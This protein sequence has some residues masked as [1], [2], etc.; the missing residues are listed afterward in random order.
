MALRLRLG[1]NAGMGDLPEAAAQAGMEVWL[2]GGGLVVTASERAARALT[3]AYHRARRAEG[4]VAWPAPQIQ[5]WQS[6]IRGAWNARG[7]GR[8]LLNT[9]QEQELW[10]QIVGASQAGSALLECSRQRMAA[11]AMEG[12]AL[13]CAYA[14][15]YLPPQQRPGWQQDAEAFS[16]WLAQFDETC[17]AERLLS[18]AR[19]PLE[20]LP[21]VAAESGERPALLL[22]GFDRMLPVQRRIF[23]A[24]GA[25]RPALAGAAAAQV[26][27]YEAADTHRELMACA[28][29]CERQL[30]LNPSARLLV[31]TQD[32]GT[33]RGEVER[34]FLRMA[35]QGSV[36]P[37]FEFSLGV[38]LSSIPLAR[39]ARLILRWLDGALE[40]QEIDWL[41]SSGLTTA[42]EAELHALTGFMRALRRRGLERLRWGLDEF[43]AQRPGPELPQEWVARTAQA[44]RLLAA[45]PR[46]GQTALEWAELVPQ[47]LE[48]AGWPHPEGSRRTLASAEFQA[49]RRWRQTL[50]QCAS[51]G[52]SGK[53]IAWSEFLL[54]LSRALDETLYAPESRDA[55]VQ[56]AGP[57]ESAG[58]AADA[59]WFMGATDD[60]WPAGGSAHPL[61]PIEIQRSVGMPHS[62]AQLDGELARAVTARLLASAPAVTFS[63]ARQSEGVE[64]RASR[65]VTRV[66]GAARA[67]PPELVGRDAPES[68]A[69]RYEDSSRIPLAEDR[70]AGGSGVLTAQS[71]CPFKA[72]ATARLDAQGW[73]PAQ[74][75]LT[76]A[77]RGNL[78]HEVL[79]SVWGTNP[80]SIR[81]HRELMA[82]EDLEAFVE[83]HVHNVAAKKMPTAARAQ[84][85]QRY[86]ALEEERL[87]RVVSEWLEFERTRADFVVG[88]T[89]AKRER[90][91]AGLA[92]RLRLD[93]ID[94]LKDE[95]VLVMDYKTGPVSTK[96]WELPRPDDVQLPLYAG[97]ALDGESEP[98]GGLVFAKVRAGENDFAG[99]V[100]NAQETLL[101][102]LGSGTSLVKHPLKLEELIAWRA[103]IEQ[104]ARDFIGGRA[105]VDPRDVRKTCERCDLQV[106]CRIGENRPEAGEEDEEEES[107]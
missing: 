97:F 43:T 100:G 21:L 39:G 11:M 102:G 52:F 46:R 19:L 42:D 103:C 22:A 90:S 9:L 37:R 60:A 57:A 24:W 38:P 104:L 32:V 76:A 33:R 13:L 94:R 40:E 44:R 15:R 17:R 88:E 53:R 63:Y 71:Q 83:G 26:S 50:D 77:E 3:A 59:I 66:A 56:I 96:L 74:A 29:W 54:A 36:R 45:R 16:G 69:T 79:H 95:T 81:S 87:I 4:L 85:P 55:P 105:D 80:D 82:I 67:L 89:E 6:F 64:A 12:Y 10:A 20:L 27:L 65:L 73:E 51:L 30:A 78:L 18:G 58:L 62:T 41:F 98:L 7:D 47:L 93:R 72:F 35:A 68:I 34:A 86:L 1:Y 2:R 101:P 106:L 91:V 8:L 99:R 5:D 31:I 107:E 92:L 75:G 84:M 28:R 14:P 49:L 25:W 70:A 23:D 48:A 61:I